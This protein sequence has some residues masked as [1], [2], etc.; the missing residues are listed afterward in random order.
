MA[1]RL[2]YGTVAVDEERGVT[3]EMGSQHRDIANEVPYFYVKGELR[4]EF[5]TRALKGV[6][7]GDRRLSRGDTPETKKTLATYV[8]ES[9]IEQGLSRALRANSSIKAD[10]V[11]VKSEIKEAMFLMGS[12][13]GVYLEYVPSYFVDFAA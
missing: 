8:S 2:V 1:F 7:S 5:F 9:S 12:L 10:L 4:F 13:G 6:P 3:V 11:D